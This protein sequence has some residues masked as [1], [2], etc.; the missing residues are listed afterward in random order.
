MRGRT[1]R[2]TQRRAENTLQPV[3]AASISSA[4]VP[5]SEL[6]LGLSPG[7][8]TAMLALPGTTA[9]MPPPTPDLSRNAD[10]EGEVATRVIMAAGEHERIDAPRALG[11]ND[12]AGIGMQPVEHQEAPGA[13]E[14]DAAHRDGALMEIA[15]Q[16]QLDG[17]M[18]IAEG[19][20]VIGERDVAEAGLALAPR[21]ALV[22]HDGL[23]PAR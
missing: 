5:S 15:A 11:G 22:D 7:D 16:H 9:R 17:M 4:R 13:G 21:H 3:S 18:D 1:K 23:V 8:Q 20:H 12:P 6:P 2:A 14:L 19:A 10:A